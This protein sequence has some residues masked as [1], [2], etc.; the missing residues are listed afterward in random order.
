MLGISTC[1]WHEKVDRADRIVNDIVQLGLG[2]VELE[3]RI[4]T[5]MYQEMKPLLK[6]A[7]RVLSI[8][9]FFPL[10]E[11]FG[12][13]Q[14]SG[15]LFLL[16]SADPE[17][18]S[19]AVKYTIQTI[20]H[21]HDLEAH[22]VIL[23]LGRVDMSN[24][25]ET[26]SSLHKSGRMDEKD[27][28]AL[29]DEQRG[30]RQA[31]HQ[32]NLDAILLSLEALTIEAERKGVFLGV[33]NRYHF[34]EIPDF[35]EIGFILKTFQGGH[36]GYWH[37]VGHARVQE[38]LGILSRHQ[39]LEAYSER[40]IGIHLHDVRGTEDHLA[41]GQG[42]IDFEEI[43]PYL[44]AS[45]PKILEIDPCRANRKDLTEGIRLIQSRGL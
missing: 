32:K 43:K 19:R 23:H 16:S 28:L 37:D 15:D 22:A 45:V 33:E 41:P 13:S 20:E 21:A 35:G 26:F 3:Y 14:G 34:H 9:N 1:W 30:I 29:I 12:L 10:P 40:M 38:N 11:D 25:T 24:P 6:G 2:G 17:E 27:M 36:I 39:L 4:T 7:V 18:R 5:S 31:M 8:H 42:E 44:N